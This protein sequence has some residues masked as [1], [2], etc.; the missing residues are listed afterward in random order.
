MNKTSAGQ[1]IIDA[2]QNAVMEA[3][4]NVSNI[5]SHTAN[6]IDG[7]HEVFY[8]S[9]EF[10]VGMAFLLVVLGLF[11]P[12]TKI[13]RAMLRRK[14]SGIISRLDEASQLQVDAQKLLSEYERK[15]LSAKDEADTILKK[16]QKE[17]DYFKTES[18]S[19]LEQ[20]MKLKTSEA[21]ERLNS[22]KEKASQEITS[23]TSELAIQAV[24]QAIYSKLDNKEKS[25]L[26]DNS[27]DLL[28]KIKA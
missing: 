21:E 9:A 22:A 15:Y 28:S 17:V 8:M 11:R 6:E 2:T 4:Q 24:K 7:H 1:E 10:W 5:M 14:I 26:I 13:I 18:L 25:K 12:I 27:I 19:R 3:A 20:E 16:S 23:L